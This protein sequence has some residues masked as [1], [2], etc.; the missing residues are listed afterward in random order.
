MQVCSCFRESYCSPLQR[1][2]QRLLPKVLAHTRLIHFFL[3][4]EGEEHP[5]WD[6]EVIKQVPLVFLHVN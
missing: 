5:I 4:G 1:Y 6:V 3:K 2:E